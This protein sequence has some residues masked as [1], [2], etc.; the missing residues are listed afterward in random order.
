[1]RAILLLA[2]ALVLLMPASSLV[3]DE[4]ADK[5]EGQA[6]TMAMEYGLNR[7]QIGSFDE[8]LSG[9]L[10]RF[11]LV[12]L[13]RGRYIEA[14]RFFWKAILVNPTSNVAWLYYDQAVI[15]TL[16]DEVPR[17]PSLVGLPGLSDEPGAKPATAKPEEEEGC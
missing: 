4:P 8:E 2:V 9:R 1:M 6:V 7:A 14:K 5:A 12:S 3:A 16:A 17:V 11:G 13:K 10:V 15:H